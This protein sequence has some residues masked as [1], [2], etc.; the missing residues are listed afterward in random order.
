[1]FDLP[2]RRR[3]PVQ[4]GFSVAL[5]L[6]TNYPEVTGFSPAR[7]GSQSSALGRLTLLRRRQNR[8]DS[9]RGY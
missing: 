5:L 2:N 4:I 1:M 6:S 8:L 3:P 7:A 9:G